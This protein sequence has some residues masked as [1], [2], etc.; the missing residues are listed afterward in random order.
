MDGSGHPEQGVP[1][2]R[3]TLGAFLRLPEGRAFLVQVPGV[4]NAGLSDEQIATLTNWS[5]A[6]FSVNTLPPQWPPYT[7]AEVTTAKAQRPADV[8]AARLALVQ[9][10]RALGAWPD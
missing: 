3:G 9:R 10:L 2:M 7:A 1:T 8:A 5:L 4:N 6:Q